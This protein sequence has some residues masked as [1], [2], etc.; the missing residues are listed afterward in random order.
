MSKSCSSNKGNGCVRGFTREK[1]NRCDMGSIPC[2]M[3]SFVYPTDG[4]RYIPPNSTPR[5][6]LE[7]EVTRERLLPLRTASISYQLP[8]PSGR[9][10]KPQRS[11]RSPSFPS[12]DTS[13][14]ISTS[15]AKRLTVSAPS[16]PTTGARPMSPLTAVQEF[17]PRACIFCIN[18][19]KACSEC[20][21]LGYVQRICKE[22]HRSQHRRKGSLP[23][24]LNQ[25][26]IKI[27]EQFFN[28]SFTSLSESSLSHPFRNSSEADLSSYSVSLDNAKGKKVQRPF[29]SQLRSKSMVS[30][31]LSSTVDT[32]ISTPNLTPL[33]EL[34][35]VEGSA[36]NYMSIDHDDVNDNTVDVNINENPEFKKKKSLKAMVMSAIKLPVLFQGNKN[37]EGRSN[38]GH[39]H[40]RQWS[41]RSISMVHLPTTSTVA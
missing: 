22:C 36:S 32:T 41:L 18:G 11:S 38:N 6:A 37:N 4:G 7:K 25:F 13:F 39:N 12:I 26:G 27:K 40:R 8:P 24:S 28:P 14:N 35:E 31:P 20:F 21:G 3:C 19:K 34:N 2:D 9:S 17:T 15:S 29:F 10:K 30:L 5:N 23:T 1:C 33:V 16:S